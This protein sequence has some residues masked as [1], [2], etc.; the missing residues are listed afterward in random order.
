MEKFINAIKKYFESYKVDNNIDL[1]ELSK[2]EKPDFSKLYFKCITEYMEPLEGWN[3]TI[4]GPSQLNATRCSM[5]H[6]QLDKILPGMDPICKEISKVSP[7]PYGLLT[8]AYCYWYC[9]KQLLD[10]KSPLK[11]KKKKATKRR[12]QWKE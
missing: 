6:K 1:F 8:C 4:T 5:C 10:K 11:L 9:S 3:K 2:L 7:Y 12:T